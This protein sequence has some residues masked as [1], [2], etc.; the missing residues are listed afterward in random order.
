M[1]LKCPLRRFLKT[2]RWLSQANLPSF[3]FYCYPGAC[4][5]KRIYRLKLSASS[6]ERKMI[7]IF[8][9]FYISGE[10]D[11]VWTQD[12]WLGEEFF[13]HW[14]TTC[15]MAKRIW[16]W[17]VILSIHYA[18]SMLLFFSFHFYPFVV[19][20]SL[21]L[22]Y[23]SPHPLSMFPVPYM[24]SLFYP[25]CKMLFE[26]NKDLSGGSIGKCCSVYLCID[27]HAIRTW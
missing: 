2:S 27:K 4:L 6:R 8:L 10:E 23:S 21:H 24:H 25:F 22:T 14:I 12:L 20:L 17:F 15:H 18:T 5:C 16:S 1:L 19:F 9:F 11:L 7:F 3:A 13:Y 26:D